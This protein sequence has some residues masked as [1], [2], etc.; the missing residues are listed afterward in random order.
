MAEFVSLY[1]I[2]NIT[3]RILIRVRLSMEIYDNVSFGNRK[4]LQHLVGYGG[5]M[6]SR[7]IGTEPIQMAVGATYYS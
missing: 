5:S 4:W 6:H 2:D 1:D 7:S 3:M